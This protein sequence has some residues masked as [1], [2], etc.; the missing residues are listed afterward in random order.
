MDFILAQI[1]GGIG[2][3]VG[4]VG[5]GGGGAVI[6][7]LLTAATIGLVH[8]VLGPDHYIP[9]I[10]MSKARNWSL[11]KTLTISGI[12]GVGHVLGSV[13]LGAIGIGFG[14]AV[15]GVKAL[16]GFRGDLAAWLLLG[17][18]LAY[19]AWGIRRAIRGKPHTHLHAHAGGIVHAHEHD[20]HGEHAHAHTESTASITP[21]V[22]FTIFVF[23]PCEPLIPILMYP[24]AKLDWWGV[25]L[26]TLVFGLCTVGM[27]V[28]IVAAGCTGLRMVRQPILARYTHVLAGLAIVACGVAIHMGL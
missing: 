6:P 10:A 11:P 15:G 8:T 7:L 2:A 16:E 18:G 9:F 19:T 12:C 17:F 14:L 28:L 24:A 3:E 21:W 1:A 25:V 27:I 4:A 20:H 13:V 5:A 22:L 26:V 23:G